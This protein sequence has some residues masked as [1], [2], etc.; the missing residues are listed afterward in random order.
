MKINSLVIIYL[1]L[2]SLDLSAKVNIRIESNDSK[3]L[4]ERKVFKSFEK[5]ALDYKASLEKV[6]EE[7]PRLKSKDFGIEMI[8]YNKKKIGSLIL[9]ETNPLTEND[10]ISNWDKKNK[11]ENKL[12]FLFTNNN[13]AYKYHS[14]N[15]SENLKNEQILPLV[16]K[17]IKEQIVDEESEDKTKLD[18]ALNAVK[19]ACDMSFQNKLV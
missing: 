1:L 7:N 6:L 11:T 4:R 16:E 14:M 12:M 18:F 17:Y 2:L 5:I 10:I 19:N 8:F 13:D 15:I 9:K 3:E